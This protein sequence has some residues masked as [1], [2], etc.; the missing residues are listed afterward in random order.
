MRNAMDRLVSEAFGPS[1]FGTIWPASDNDKSRTLVPIDAYATEDEVVVLAAIPGVSAGDIQINIEKNTVSI[2][3]D[4][5]SVTKSDHAKGANWYVHELA[6]GSFRRSL[7]L[8]VE[9]D[10]SKAE[11]TF[12]SGILRL[13]LP[14]A[15]AA[16]P[17]QIQ[18][19]VGKP[20]TDTPAIAETADDDQ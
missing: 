2:S 16:K 9:I 20:A 19:Q 4:V 3:G 14:K 13:T 7:T 8:P 18:V 10:A 5:P 12:E 17:R 1:H 15:E 11:A 6:S